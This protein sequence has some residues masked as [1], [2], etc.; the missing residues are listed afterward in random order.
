VN[1]QPK[2]PRFASCPVCWAQHDILDK[3][4]GW[5]LWCGCNRWLVV[6]HRTDGSSQ[7]LLWGDFYFR[8]SPIGGSNNGGQG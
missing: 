3:L 2:Q 1:Q 5:R 7:L 8:D 6:E 4:T